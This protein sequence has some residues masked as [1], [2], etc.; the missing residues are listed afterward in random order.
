MGR[1]R[2]IMDY[3]EKNLVFC[4]LE[5]GSHHDRGMARIGPFGVAECQRRMNII[6]HSNT[7]SF[8]NTKSRSFH[9]FLLEYLL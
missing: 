5:H 7:L 6:I 2:I 1:K 3:V 8:T 9:G 4:I